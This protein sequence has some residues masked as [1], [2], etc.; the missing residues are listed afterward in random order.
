LDLNPEQVCEI[1]AFVAS[2][3]DVAS[4]PA[5]SQKCQPPKLCAEHIITSSLD[6][7]IDMV[8]H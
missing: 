6:L 4:Q 1:K 7:L 2:M 8:G 5:K 3:V